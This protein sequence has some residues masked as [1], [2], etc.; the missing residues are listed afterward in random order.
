M[1]YTDY[2]SIPKGPVLKPTMKEFTNFR[3]YVNHIESI[4]ELAEYGMVKVF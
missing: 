2:T 3:D 4:P 1:K